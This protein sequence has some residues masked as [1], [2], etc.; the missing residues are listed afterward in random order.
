MNTKRPKTA[1]PQ[2]SDD[3]SDIATYERAL[4][5]PPLCALPDA[6]H[7]AAAVAHNRAF[8]AFGTTFQSILHEAAT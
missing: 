4:P 5:L 8:A 3:G 7:E 6:E 2:S 1:R